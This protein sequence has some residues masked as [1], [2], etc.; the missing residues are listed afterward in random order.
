MG[1]LEE[2][3]RSSRHCERSGAIHGPTERMDVSLDRDTALD[4]AAQSLLALAI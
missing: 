3:A 1:T 4:N 2:N